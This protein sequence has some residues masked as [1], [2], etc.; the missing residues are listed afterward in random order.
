MPT[1]LKW[2]AILTILV[3]TIIV[4]LVLFE[5]E[6][7]EIVKEVLAW[8]DNEPATTAAVLIGALAADV[9]LPVPNGIINTLAGSLFGW[10]VGALIIWIGLTAGC[11]VGYGAG[12]FAGMPLV[13]RFVGNEDLYAAQEFAARSGGPTL[14]ITRAVPMFGDLSTIAAG[15]TGYPF[16]RYMLIVSLANIGVAVVFAGIGSAATETELLAILG[17]IVLPGLAWVGYRLFTRLQR[18]NP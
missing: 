4:P 17:A 5:S 1:W 3:T 11:V 15:M 2:V 9:F 18:T 14:V 13:S 8:A 16:I 10:V 7:N 12:K 6:S